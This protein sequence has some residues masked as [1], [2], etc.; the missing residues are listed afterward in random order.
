MSSV[1]GLDG[2]AAVPQPAPSSPQD[3]ELTQQLNTLRVDRHESISLCRAVVRH[4]V[5]WPSAASAIKTVTRQ[6]RLQQIH[7]S[8]QCQL[9]F[10]GGYKHA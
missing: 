2:I 5:H 6:H 4:E 7:A 8:Y 3:V 10:A 9:T 1:L